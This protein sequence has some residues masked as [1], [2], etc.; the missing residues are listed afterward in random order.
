MRAYVI[1]M[2]ESIVRV[3]E[4]KARKC[5]APCQERQREVA[6]RTFGCKQAPKRE[7]ERHPYEAPKTDVLH[8]V[9]VFG[10]VDFPTVGIY[11]MLKV[12]NCMPCYEA[13]DDDEHRLGF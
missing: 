9:V 10:F 3:G 1:D 7:H 4:A 2:D 12:A 13:H 6:V 11:E 5:D 8:M